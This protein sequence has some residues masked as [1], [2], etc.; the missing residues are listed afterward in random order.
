MPDTL[1]YKFSYKMELTPLEADIRL[2]DF[3][4]TSPWREH[5]IHFGAGPCVYWARQKDGKDVGTPTYDYLTKGARL[6]GQRKERG[7]TQSNV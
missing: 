7:Y 4:P 3:H 6:R 2:E 1:T 5:F